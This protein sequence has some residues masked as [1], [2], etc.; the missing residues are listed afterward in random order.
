MKI[1]SVMRRFKGVAKNKQT[2]KAGTI[3]E[4]SAEEKAPVIVRAHVPTLAPSGESWWADNIKT[5]VQ[6]VQSLGAHP[7]Q[8]PYAH[9]AYTAEG[10]FMLHRLV[11]EGDRYGKPSL[12]RFQIAFKDT[13]DSNNL[14]DLEVTSFT[15][16]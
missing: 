16:E 10:E 9:N 7:K 15:L 13:V 3:I 4:Y 1:K 8:K 5:K 14:P 12:K 11:H 2:A 6:D